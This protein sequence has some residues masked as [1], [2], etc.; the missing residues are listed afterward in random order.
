MRQEYFPAFTFWHNGQGK[1]FRD[2]AQLCRL[3]KLDSAQSCVAGS[4]LFCVLFQVCLSG[5]PFALTH[6]G[7]LLFPLFIHG[8]A[9]KDKLLTCTTTLWSRG[10]HGEISTPITLHIYIS[11]LCVKHQTPPPRGYKCPCLPHSRNPRLNEM[12]LWVLSR[13]EMLVCKRQLGQRVVSKL[14]HD[15]KKDGFFK[16]LLI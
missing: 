12:Q 15:K 11:L 6:G 8:P 1:L 4:F 16:V 3:L 13:K 14:C 5:T 9:L 7:H 10:L 2:P